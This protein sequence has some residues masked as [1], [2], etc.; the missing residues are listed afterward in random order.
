MRENTTLALT[1]VLIKSPDLKSETCPLPT[2]EVWTVK[3]INVLYTP[4]ALS[5]CAVLYI[6]TLITVYYTKL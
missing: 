6:T 5:G 4:S 2:T 1:L 3:V